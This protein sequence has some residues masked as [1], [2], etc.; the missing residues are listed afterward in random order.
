MTMQLDPGRLRVTFAPGTLPEE[1]VVPRAYTL[2]H[3]DRTGDQVGHHCGSGLRR[4]P[5][6]QWYA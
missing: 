3:S 5:R 4:M 1:P 6:Q 2:T